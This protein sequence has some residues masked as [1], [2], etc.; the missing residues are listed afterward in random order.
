LLPDEAG[1]LDGNPQIL[2]DDYVELGQIQ[3]CSID[4]R[5]DNIGKRYWPN[6]VPLRQGYDDLTRYSKHKPR[7][8]TVV[9]VQN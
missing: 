7:W 3:R 4:K 9:Y 6:T 2:P 8:P 5:Q 1:R